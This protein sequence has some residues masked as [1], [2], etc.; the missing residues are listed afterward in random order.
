MLTVR[1]WNVALDE[2]RIGEQ[3]VLFLHSPSNESG[4]TSPVGGRLGHL[5]VEQVPPA[6]LEGLRVSNQPKSVKQD[7]PRRL[8]RRPARVIWKGRQP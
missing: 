6:L 1:Q 8:S 3:L 2:Y 7:A 5:R 4:F